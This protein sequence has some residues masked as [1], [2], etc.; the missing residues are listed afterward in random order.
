V[1]DA[2][3]DINAVSLNRTE[4]DTQTLLMVRIAALAAIDAPAMSYLMHVGPAVAAGLTIEQVQDVL[5]AVAPIAGTPRVLAAAQNI[6]AAL[7]LAVAGLED[8][9]ELGNPAPAGG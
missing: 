7:G 3:V 5:V 1:L 9:T 4:L 6:T 2:L 8:L